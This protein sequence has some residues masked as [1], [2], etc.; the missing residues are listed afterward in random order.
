MELAH[1]EGIILVGADL[2]GSLIRESGLNDA[3]LEGANLRNTCLQQSS[4][5]RANLRNANLEGADLLEAI[6][7]EA[8]LEGANLTRL[9][10][11]YGSSWYH[12]NLRGAC[13]QE[14]DWSMCRWDNTIL[15]DGR[16]VTDED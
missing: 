3:N 7:D 11:V 15:P 4:F 5:L 16:V 8:N 14:T 9:Y 1:L 6:L 10:S 13:I 12:A 2:S